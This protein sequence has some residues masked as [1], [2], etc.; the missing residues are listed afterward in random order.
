M[1]RKSKAMMNV[2]IVYEWLTIDEEGGTGFWGGGC[3]G[4]PGGSAMFVVGGGGMLGCALVQISPKTPS[5]GAKL[6]EA[7]YL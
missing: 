5:G 3:L 6:V 4:R 2:V 1:R 7:Y